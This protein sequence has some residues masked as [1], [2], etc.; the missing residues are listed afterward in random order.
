M[1]DGER[2]ADTS[3]PRGYFEWEGIKQLVTKPELL[4]ETN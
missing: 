4:D 3:N 2:T 1:T